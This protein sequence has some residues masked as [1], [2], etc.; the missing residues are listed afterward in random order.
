MLLQNFLDF[1]YRANTWYK[2]HT[3]SEIRSI[4]IFKWQTYDEMYTLLGPSL[5]AVMTLILAL[6]RNPAKYKFLNTL[7]IWEWQ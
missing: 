7:F 3:L 2:N 1:L 5:Q 4:S 6:L